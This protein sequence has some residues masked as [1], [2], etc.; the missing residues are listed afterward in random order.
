M[1]IR[2]CASVGVRACVQASSSINSSMLLP[3]VRMS[4]Q[5][6]VGHAQAAIR[7]T[8][9]AQKKSVILT[10]FL[11]EHGRSNS[12][13]DRWRRNV[14]LAEPGILFSSSQGRSLHHYYPSLFL[15]AH[16]ELSYHQHMVPRWL[17]GLDC[18]G[19]TSSADD[20]DN[21]YL[22][23]KYM[24]GASLALMTKRFWIWNI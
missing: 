10:H 17:Q 2:Y 4:Q 21:N 13:T 11:L 9:L 7:S 15:S 22:I 1:C 8:K 19:F 18:W 16:V 5:R 6:N 23:P 24:T 20:V 14:I 12:R 3:T